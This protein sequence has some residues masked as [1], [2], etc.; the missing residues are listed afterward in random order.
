MASLRIVVV[1]AL[2]VYAA[3]LA[4]AILI[5]SDDSTTRPPPGAG[6]YHTIAGIHRFSSEKF[7]YSG[8]VMPL[9]SRFQDGDYDRQHSPILIYENDKPL[10]FPHTRPD[11]IEDI[12]RG[13]YAH[14]GTMFLFSTSDNSDPA[15]NGR[16]YWAV[17]PTGAENNPISAAPP[18]DDSGH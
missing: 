1:C 4:V 17:Y 8:P 2:S 6:T 11:A 7:M 16:S 5:R 3:F 13:R 15:T 9:F 12:G 18:A 14:L 10:P